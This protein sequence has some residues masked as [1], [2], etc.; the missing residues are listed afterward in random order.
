MTTRRHYFNNNL[1]SLISG[2]MSK[3]KGLLGLFP[4]AGFPPALTVYSFLLDSHIVGSEL[5]LWLWG[6][7]I[8]VCVCGW[9]CVHVCAC[10]CMSEIDIRCFSFVHWVFMCTCMHMCFCG[11]VRAHMCM[12]WE[13][14]MCAQSPEV[15][16]DVFIPFPEGLLPTST[17]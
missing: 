15:M 3:P 9:V 6:K 7:C 5:C 2:A 10:V 12:L 1:F 16:Q 4:G 13:S 14:P 17:C 11:C 8:C